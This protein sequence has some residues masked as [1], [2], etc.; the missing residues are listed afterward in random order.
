MDREIKLIAFDLDD[1]L[2]NSKKEITPETL[3]TLEKAASMGI[4]ILP[5]TGRFFNAVPENVKSLKFVRY[6]ATLNGA[7]LF[8]IKESK[9]LAKFMIP[10][11]TAI[12]IA[13]VC[14]GLTKDSIYDAVVDGQGFMTQECFDRIPEC[15]MGP[16]QVNLVSNF[17]TPTNDL[18]GVI[19]NSAGVQKMQ[20]YTL[21]KELRADL[22]KALPVV[23]P[24]C[25]ITS[26]IKNNIEINDIT[27]SKGQALKFLADKLG[28]SLENV[29][30]FGD[31]TNDIS[32][33]KAAGI[34][35]AMGNAADELKEAA[36]YIT[37]DCNNNGVA[38]GIKKFCFAQ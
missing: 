3:E 14:E 20:I 24:Q 16:W 27:A 12:T 7:E 23:F 34:G 36:D 26:A 25:L 29:L 1:T 37:T 30:A 9:S 19:A 10:P 8:D 38:E 6:M 28:I 33:I 15:M 21:N 13:R 22:L 5:V 17:R 11:E 4:E 31:G 32:M 2:F 35:V 18:Y